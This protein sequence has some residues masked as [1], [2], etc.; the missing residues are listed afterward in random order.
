MTEALTRTRSRTFVIDA[1][2]LGL[3]ESSGA[4]ALT[5]TPGA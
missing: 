1:V 5:G 2:D 4:G 3:C